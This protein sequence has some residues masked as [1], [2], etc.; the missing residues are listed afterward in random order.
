MPIHKTYVIQPHLNASLLLFC[1]YMQVLQLFLGW[2][3]K[4]KQANQNED[5]KNQ[6]F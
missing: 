2:R 1:Y 5:Q 3:V 4:G 6:S